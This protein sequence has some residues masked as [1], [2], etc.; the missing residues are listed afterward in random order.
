MVANYLYPLGIR[1]F[2]DELYY[3]LLLASVIHR[4]EGN[5]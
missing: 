4:M 1:V 5:S 3:K 2:N